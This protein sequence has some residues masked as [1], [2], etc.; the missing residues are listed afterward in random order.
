MKIGIVGTPQVG[1]STIF[2][3]LTNVTAAVGSKA[4]QGIAKV[5]DLRVDKLSG[6]F[7]PKKTTY[8][9]IEFVDIAGVIK[10]QG[11]TR[12]FLNAIRD[13]DALVQVVRAFESEMVPTVDGS[14]DPMKDLSEIQEELL[15]TDWSFLETRLERLEKQ[16]AK[17]PNAAK[18]LALLEKC[19]GVLEQDLPLR[20]LELSQEE[21]KLIRGYEFFT[22]KPLII[23]A[24]LDEN[25]IQSGQFPNKAQL[26]AWVTER[27]IPLV[28][29][30]GQVEME[31]SQ[32]ESEDAKEFM[33]ELGIEQPG[34][35]R[36]AQAVYQHLGLI[37]Y[38]TVGEDEVRAWT[39]KKGSTARQAAGKIHSDIERG[40]IRAEVTSYPDF[41]EHGSIQ[42]LKERG[43]YRLE[44]KDYI[45]Q[46]GDI[47]SFRFNV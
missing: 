38:F 35:A 37:S 2:Q 46:D 30:S 1:K 27:D 9:T 43:L 45:V 36:L 28:E 3:L 20:T 40:F 11:N 23:V 24:N 18:E 34:I 12:E 39:I 31:I 21:E 29:M 41:I 47:M 8:A 17:D 4:N 32:L 6:M 7:S 26:V 22:K 15:L 16:R 33:S 13:V 14:I 19:K 42:A 25:Q 10:G 44:G 5:P